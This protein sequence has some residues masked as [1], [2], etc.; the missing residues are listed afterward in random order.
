MSANKQVPMT[1]IAIYLEF[2]SRMG[3]V[4]INDVIEI[5]TINSIKNIKIGK[6]RDVLR[7][8]VELF[9]CKT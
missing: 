9:S 1:K 3:R 6:K 2:G 8:L 7:L 5:A 4:K